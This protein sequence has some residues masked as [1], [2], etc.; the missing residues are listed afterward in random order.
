MKK[1]DIDGQI[2]SESRTSLV[3]IKRTECRTYQ[4]QKD[5][6]SIPA[7]TFIKTLEMSDSMTEVY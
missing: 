3:S 1:N 2:L 6:C 4:D 5:S 7:V